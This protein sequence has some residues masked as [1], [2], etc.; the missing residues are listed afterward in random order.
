MI[1]SSVVEG[2]V[3]VIPSRPKV[4]IVEDENIVA[5][6]IRYHLDLHGYEVIGVAESGRIAI[7]IAQRIRPDVIVMDIHIKSDLNGIET[8]V[9][10][11]GLFDKPIPIV[12][13]TAYWKE[14]HS[15]SAALNNYVVVK[16]PFS[17]KELTSGMLKV[18]FENEM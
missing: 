10:L 17:A 5:E 15:L 12:F 2:G 6:D 9:C 3:R 1:G 16:K 4:L 8:A 11:Q 7:Q 13:I 14:Q 18:M